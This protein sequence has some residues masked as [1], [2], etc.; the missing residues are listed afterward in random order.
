MSGS[1]N[2]FSH[3]KAQ[4]MS[5]LTSFIFR[6]PIGALQVD[7]AVDSLRL[8]MAKPALVDRLCFL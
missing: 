3:E 8:F 5:A 7:F 2:S 1:T 6:A 4:E